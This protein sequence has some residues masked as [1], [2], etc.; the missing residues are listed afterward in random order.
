MREF[1]PFKGAASPQPLRPTGIGALHRIMVML[2][3]LVISPCAGWVLGAALLACGSLHAQQHAHTHG[4][5]SMDVAVDPQALSLHLST[6]L[7]SFLGFE[8]APRTPQEQQQVHAMLAQLQAVSQW[9]R[10]DPAAA[11]TLEHIEIDAP[12]LELGDGQSSAHGHHHHDTPHA[13]TH[14]HG[15]AHG[16]HADMDISIVFACPQAEQAQFIDLD[17]F[18]HYGRL[19]HIEVQ[20]AT[21]HGQFKRQLQRPATRLSLVR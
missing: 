18:Q 7:D 11:C 10:P 20:V 9:L 2:R 1:P 6:P 21:P 16:A 14:D 8:R 19:Q 4:R 3:K 12:V 17:V 15:H 13:E 5:L